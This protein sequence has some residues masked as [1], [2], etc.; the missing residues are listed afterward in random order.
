[1]LSA[2]EYASSPS[3]RAQ[4]RTASRMPLPKSVVSQHFSMSST[5][6]QR[7]ALWKPSA[8][9]SARR[10]E[11]VLHLVAVVEDLGLARDDRLERRLGDAR[12]ALERVAHLRLLLRELRARTRDPGSG[13]RRTSGKC[14]HGASTRCGPARDDLGRERLRV[15]A[16]HLRHAR[17]HAIA[18]QPAPH[19]DDEPVEP[20]DAVAAVRERLDVE[21]ELLILRHRR[22]H[23]AHSVT[24]TRT[25]DAA[26]GCSGRRGFCAKS[27]SLREVAEDLRVLPHVGRGSGRPSVVGFEPLAAEEVVL[28]EL[29]V[30]VGAQ[31]LVVDVAALR[32]RADHE[33]R[34]AQPVAVRVDGRRLHVVVEAAP[35]VPARKIAVDPVGSA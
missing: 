29:Q 12:D 3:S 7:P 1:M 16:L 4:S 19:E 11:R 30:R 24:R 34:H 21:L 13:S 35:V 27:K 33:R 17:A 28:D 6:S 5:S 15:P 31:H 14:S 2:C 18:G 8:G 10:R 25:S 32:V 9:P 23:R 22:G 26:A 20:R